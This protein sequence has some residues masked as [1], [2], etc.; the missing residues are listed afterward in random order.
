MFTVLLSYCLHPPISKCDD[1]YAHI[2]GLYQTSNRG[3][4]GNVWLQPCF[5]QIV[6]LSLV[7]AQT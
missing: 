1:V 3:I 6:L 2:G 4:L 7:T 5:V